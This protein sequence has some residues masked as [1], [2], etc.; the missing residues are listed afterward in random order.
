MRIVEIRV[1]PENIGIVDIFTRRYLLQDLLFSAGK[2]LKDSPQ[3]SVLCRQ[4]KD[5]RSCQFSSN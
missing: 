3:L 1:E 5:K 4:Q 2:T